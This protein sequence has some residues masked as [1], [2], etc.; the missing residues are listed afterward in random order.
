MVVSRNVRCRRFYVDNLNVRGHLTVGMG[1]FPE[2]RELLRRHKPGL[3][4][5]CQTGQLIEEPL[6]AL[7]QIPGMDDIPLILVHEDD[8]LPEWLAGYALATR[9]RR[10][11]DAR[12]LL[13]ALRPWLPT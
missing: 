13:D 2:G 6:L 10:P 9:I 7:K 8:P 11:V 1:S 5:H 4:I 3:I 12:R